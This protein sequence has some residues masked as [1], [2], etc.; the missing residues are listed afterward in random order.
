M[1]AIICPALG[2]VTARFSQTEGWPIETSDTRVGRPEGRRHTS[3]VGTTRLA[4]LQVGA[5]LPGVHEE[6]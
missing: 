5:T 4:D 6:C 3:K 1:Q 2:C